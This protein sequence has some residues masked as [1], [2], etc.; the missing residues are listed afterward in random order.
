MLSLDLR[1]PLR[2][3]L[4]LSDLRSPDGDNFKFELTRR[5][6]WC[7]KIILIDK[8]EDCDMFTPTGDPMLP[9]IGPRQSPSAH[10]YLKEKNCY[11]SCLKDMCKHINANCLEIQRD[12]DDI[13]LMLLLK[14]KRICV[15]NK[16][17][18]DFICCSRKMQLQTRLP[19]L[20]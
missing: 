13:T 3:H 17:M 19:R 4:K 10:H 5:C 1:D 2:W 14:Q 15:L 11:R 7:Q 18:V 20:F 6:I 16:S 12:M 9:R 8:K